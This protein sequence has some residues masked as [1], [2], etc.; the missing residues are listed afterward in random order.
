MRTATWFGLA[1]LDEL[2]ILRELLPEEGGLGR[3]YQHGL[4][5]LTWTS[6]SVSESFSLRRAGWAACNSMV[7][8]GMA[9]LDKLLI[10]RELLPEEGGLG[11]V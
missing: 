5:W 7:W 10:L 6:F 11:C 9:N 2:L 4:V 1:K 8:F 3:V